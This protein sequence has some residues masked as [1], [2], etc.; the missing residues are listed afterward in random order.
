M[1]SGMLKTSKNT[2]LLVCGLWVLAQVLLPLPQ[3]TDFSFQ[4]LVFG[5]LF[6]YSAAENYFKINIYIPHSES[7]S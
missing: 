3:P 4:I 1:S 2:L 7:K 6:E 5:N